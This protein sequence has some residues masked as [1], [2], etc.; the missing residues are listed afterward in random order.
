MRPHIQ[1]FFD[2]ATFT[3]TYLV[4]DPATR[5]A[6]VIDPVLDYE[7]KRGQL[8]TGSADQLL[9][10]I[11]NQG[12]DLK[13]LLETHAHADHLSA[14]GYIRR[15][16]GARIGIGARIVEVQKHFIPVFEA[17]DVAADGKAFDLLLNDG[18]TL[19]LGELSISVLDTPGHTAADVT[20]LVADAAFVGDTLF[21]PD[22]GTARTDFPGGDARVLYA[23]IRRI[24]ALPPQTRVFVGHDYLPAGRDTFQCESTVAEQRASNIHIGDS[25][26][27]EAFV[28]MREARDATLSAPTLILPSL[29]VNIRGGELPQASASGRVF[30]KIPV[31]MVGAGVA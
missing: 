6:A 26:T 30:L 22:Y 16:T 17:D 7:P 12:L 23:S 29:Q 27:E 21:M 25:V 5:A 10:A 13:Y 9:A 31:T 19:A 3:A 2:A 14:A 24:L 18:D 28:A 1:T 4:S 8:S 15:R 20:Y 11:E